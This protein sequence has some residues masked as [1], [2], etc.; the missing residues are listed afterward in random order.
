MLLAGLYLGTRLVAHGD[1]TWWIRAGDRRAVAS[2]L[3]DGFYLEKGAGYDGK[4][5]YRIARE[6]LSRAERVDGI[7]F[8]IASYRHQRWGYP[9][10]AWALATGGREGAVPWALAGVNLLAVGALSAAVAVLARDAGRSPWLG[11]SAALLPGVVTAISFDLA[12]VTEAALVAVALVLLRRQRYGPAVAVMV[13]AAVTRETALLLPLAIVGSRLLAGSGFARRWGFAARTGPP[14]WV[15]LVP[16]AAY[17]SNQLALAWWWRSAGGAERSAEQLGAPLV[18]IGRALQ[19]AAGDDP[20]AVASIVLVVL[21]AAL[22]L[23]ALRDPLAG[24]PH[25]RLA[26]VGAAI[27]TSALGPWDRAI[28]YLRYPTMLL[29]FALVV[30]LDAADVGRGTRPEVV[31]AGVIATLGLI[32]CLVFVDVPDASYEAMRIGP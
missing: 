27:V 3:P 28:V 20:R 5:Y 17:V 1:P 8:D 31:V 30:V 15:G 11:L 21:A 9:V 23:R 14:Y 22:G 18:A 4:Y 12:E 6:P 25:E 32:A 29:L 7:R 19:A 24:R 10:L 2:E 16:L 26:L 13:W